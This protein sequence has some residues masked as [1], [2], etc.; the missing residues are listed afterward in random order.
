MGYHEDVAIPCT[1]RVFRG[2]LSLFFVGPGFSISGRDV[3][4]SIKTSM[5]PGLGA[6]IGYAITP[7]F[8][9]FAGRIS[10]GSA[11]AAIPP[12]TG[13]WACSRSAAG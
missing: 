6:Q 5:G 12:V 7:Q 1:F 9:V 3:P 10:P 11:P 4:G 13:D 8:L 2:A